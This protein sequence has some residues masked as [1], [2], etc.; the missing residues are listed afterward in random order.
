MGVVCV[1]AWLASLACGE[2]VKFVFEDAG[3]DAALGGTGGGL[4]LAGTGGLS[5]S[6]GSAAAGAAGQGG[7]AGGAGMGGMPD[8]DASV[9]R[10]AAADASDAAP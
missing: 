2:T 5:G 3:P 6:A 1:G 4:N 9:P 7:S 8:M 10:D